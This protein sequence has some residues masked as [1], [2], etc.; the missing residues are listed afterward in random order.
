MVLQGLRVSVGST[1]RFV[2]DDKTCADVD[3]SA[4]RRRIDELKSPTLGPRDFDLPWPPYRSNLW[5]HMYSADY[6]NTRSVD[7]VSTLLPTLWTK[8]PRAQTLPPIGLWNVS[9]EVVRHPFALTTLVHVDPTLA[10]P[11]P[12]DAARASEGL[13]HVLR[14]KVGSAA[15]M[16]GFPLSEIPSLPK[17]SFKK[18]S[19]LTLV[20]AGRFLLISALHDQDDGRSSASVLARHFDDEPDP[21]RAFPLRS[22]KGALS[23]RGEDVAQVLPRNLPRAEQKLECLHKNAALMLAYLQNLSTVLNAPTTTACNWYREPAASD[24]SHLYRRAPLPATGSVYK[25]RIPELWL[26]GRGREAAINVLTTGLPA[27]PA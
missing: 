19:A 4:Y 22:A 23:V 25:S 20:N 3:V 10:L 9:V 26:N 6:R 14:A 16:D 11:W 21:T 2:A 18:G 13:R 7:L 27:L 5:R 12:E 15:I 1:W 17:R 8:K 24:L